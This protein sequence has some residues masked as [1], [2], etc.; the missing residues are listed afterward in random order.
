MSS[1]QRVL[2]VLARRQNYAHIGAPR[3]IRDLERVWKRIPEESR[4]DFRDF[5]PIRIITVIETVFRDAARDLIDTIPECKQRA[6]RYLAKLPSRDITEILLH[7]DQHSF[8]LGDLVCHIL[9]CNSVSDIIAALDSIYGDNFKSELADSRERWLDDDGKY[10]PPFIT[11]LNATLAIVS[12]IFSVRHILVHE[13]AREKP[14]D[15]SEIAVFLEHSSRFADA[16][17][18]LTTYKL[19]GPVPRSSYY[20]RK[21]AQERA[22]VTYKELREQAPNNIIVSECLEDLDTN[23]IWSKFVHLVADARSGLTKPASGTIAP[24]LYYG[25]VERLNR[26]RLEDIRD[27]PDREL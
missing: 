22:A 4:N 13:M 19:Q 16:L 26:W 9:S 23:L 21:M 2:E 7:L 14:Y 10:G 15:P 12:R 8:T 1:S 3:I 17:S 27:H 18:W 25:E 11:D 6:V 24:L 5:I 20:M